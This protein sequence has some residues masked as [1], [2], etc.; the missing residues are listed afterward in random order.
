MINE[1]TF[2]D[3]YEAG[4]NEDQKL[5]V[6]ST[7]GC[8]LV[9]AVP[10]SGKTTVLVTR[11]GYMIF[12]KGIPSE[13][14]LTLTYTV[15]AT[16]DMRERFVRI[17]GEEAGKIPEF[18]TLNGVCAKIILKY[19]S[20][21]GRESFALLDDERTAGIM[22]SKSFEKHT[23]DYP[24]ENEIANVKKWITYIKNMMLEEEE[25]KKLGKKERLP[26]YEIFRDYNAFL[27]S[28]GLMDYDDQLVYAYRL[29]TGVPEL[30]TYFRKLYPYI[31][32][33]EAQDTS[34][35]QHKIIALL[36]GDG[37]NLFMVGDEDQSIYGFRAAYPKAL[38]SFCED[39]PGAKLLTMRENYRS[40]GAVVAA[41]N[42]VIRNNVNRY[43]KQMVTHRPKGEA[44]RFVKVK[45]REAQTEEL[46]R[47]AQSVT[48]RTAILFRDHESIIP[49][50]DLLERRRIPFTLRASD[51]TFFSNRV[52]AD[53][54]NFFRFAMSP[55]DGELFS[56]LYY[57][58]R[59]YLTKRQMEQVVMNAG[60]TGTS[61]LAAVQQ[62]PTIKPGVKKRCAELARA[63]RNLLSDR[64]AR[65][66]DRILDEM[67]YEAYL[68]QGRIDMGAI[69]VLTSV[70]ACEKT[71][72]GFLERLSDLRRIIREGDHPVS[73]NLILSTIHSS[74]GLE[75]E[76]VWITDV[77]D[78]VFPSNDAGLSASEIEEERRLFYVGLTRAKER[79][80]L[81][82]IDKLPSRFIEEAGGPRQKQEKK[83]RKK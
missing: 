32:V 72:Q 4:L 81:F 67:E 31:C 6:E 43:E 34:L 41:A 54:T 48:H 33:D 79:L 42:Q 35:I 56:K 71:V 73:P 22:L 66:I 61:I 47:V 1:Q 58:C 23:G 80:N 11:L 26:L 18:R 5:A 9:L 37:G 69:F 25:I 28:K 17:F 2:R 57:K 75:Y 3:R 45:K 20:M 78:G 27:R 59:S 63:F 51:L 12:V 74:K 83:T 49:L 29:L 16:K 38:L 14:I 62:H 65:A 64:P 60:R 15:S 40:V 24:T 21:I 76:E 36:A 7:E 39:H 44:I 13:Q 70:A 10:G 68:K 82:S 30:L 50:A 46:L 53:I 55:S 8:V 52:V 19:A 77:F